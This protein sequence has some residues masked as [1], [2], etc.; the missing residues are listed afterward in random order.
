MNNLSS[1]SKLQILNTVS[2]AISLIGLILNVVSFG[3]HPVHI[4]S[5]L[6]FLSLAGIY[7]YVI[8]VKR[9]V[10]KFSVVV[11]DVNR[12]IFESRITHIDDGGE[13]N[14]ACWNVNN[15]LD[16]IEVFMREI[17]TP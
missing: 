17:K 14:D 5:L 1:L 4:V 15:M 16:K 2:I 9:C 7:F 10:N 13:L 8:R 12:G 6:V 3:F 11:A